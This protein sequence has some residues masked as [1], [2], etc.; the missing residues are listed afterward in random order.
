MAALFANTLSEH[1]IAEDHATSMLAHPWPGGYCPLPMMNFSNSTQGLTVNWSGCAGPYQVEWSADPVGTNWITVGTATN[2]GTLALPQKGKTGFYRIKAQAPAFAGAAK[3]QDCHSDGYDSWSQTKHAAALTSLQSVGMHTNV[4]CLPC[5]T[6]DFGIPTAFK[7]LA[8]TPA[9]AGVQCENCHGPARDHMAA[10]NDPSKMPH[11]TESAMLCAGCHTGPQ[12]PFYEEWQS[13][14]HAS[15][16][17]QVAQK[18]QAEGESAL[19]ACGTCHSGAVH[20]A[21]ED[22]NDL[23]SVQEAASLGITCEVCHDPMTEYGNSFQLR[24]PMASY[25]PYSYD[26]STN[27]TFADQY[28]P[29]LNLCARCHNLRGA[30]WQDTLE[31]PHH[32]PQYNLL[33]G[34]GGFETDTNALPPGSTGPPQSPHRTINTQCAQC[35]VHSVDVADPSPANPMIR[36]HSFAPQMTACQSCH[37]DPSSLLAYVQADTRRRIANVKGL[38]DK[39]ALTKAYN[40]LRAVYGTLSWEYNVPG[41]LS[42]PVQ[43]LHGPTPAQQAYVPDTIKQARFNLYLVQH[44]GSFGVHN[45]DYARF[46]LQVA[47]DKVNAELAR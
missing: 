17:P 39:W 11:M 40:A 19:L 29:N 37:N 2:P 10:P 21:L 15:V 22:G 46:L 28:D 5:H 16:V 31:A 26:N 25:R 7:D 45:T 18:M 6:L 4:S 43:T 41:D 13:S 44:D 27:S 9:L 12:Q 8:S 33:T 36:G 35:H 20:R 38:L 42:D 3:C 30:T 23:P 34:S 47:E 14:K 32:S 24:S 1:A